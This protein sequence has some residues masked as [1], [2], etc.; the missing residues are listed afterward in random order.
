M[1]DEYANLQIFTK[2]NREIEKYNKRKILDL[3]RQITPK[4]RKKN[5]YCYLEQ[6]H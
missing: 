3:D 5:S 1:Q 4:K 2:H 6:V